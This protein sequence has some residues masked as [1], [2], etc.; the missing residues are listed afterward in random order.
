MQTSCSISNTILNGYQGVSDL[1]YLGLVDPNYLRYNKTVSN[2]DLHTVKA[3]Y[4]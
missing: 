2:I 4:T 3:V 1:R